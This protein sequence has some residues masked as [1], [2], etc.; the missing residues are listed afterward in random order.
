ME[1]KQHQELQQ[2]HESFSKVDEDSPEAMEDSVI[3]DFED[4]SDDDQEEEMSDHD[5]DQEMLDHDQEEEQCAEPVTGTEVAVAEKTDG[6][7][8][9]DIFEILIPGDVG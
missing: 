8:L 6:K 5:Q 7:M 3:S 2:Q 4:M 1:K 9:K